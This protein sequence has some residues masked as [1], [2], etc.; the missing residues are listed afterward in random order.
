[1]KKITPILLAVIATLAILT[2]CTADTS[3]LENQIAE[4]SEQIQALS[5]ENEALRQGLAEQ[6]VAA[7]TTETEEVIA[8]YEQDEVEVLPVSVT[9]TDMNVLPQDNSVGRFSPWIGF[10]FLIE[11]NTDSD[12]RGIQGS[13]EIKDMFGVRIMDVGVDFTQDTIYA[14]QSLT[15]DT[16]GLDVNRFLDRHVQVYSS[17]FASLMFTYTIS[18]VLFTDGTEL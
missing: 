1:M 13:L 18:R 15:I 6:G 8:V 14:H 12:I 17:D 11:N 3:N 10:E 5:A 4:L 16:L 2:A 7:A 9:V